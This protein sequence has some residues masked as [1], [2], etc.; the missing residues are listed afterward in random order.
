[1]IINMLGQLA[2]MNFPFFIGL[3]FGNL[4]KLFIFVAAVIVICDDKFRPVFLITLFGML[5]S[6]MMIF[7][8]MGWHLWSD[9][10]PVVY[11]IYFV[12]LGVFFAGTRFA[13]KEIKL[14]LA[15][16]VTVPILLA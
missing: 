15:S 4:D 11:G 3:L 13:D 10:F 16:F 12:A 5:Y 2:T 7:H 6:M 14:L 9:V 1:M 8:L